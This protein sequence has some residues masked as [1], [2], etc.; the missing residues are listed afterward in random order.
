MGR[1]IGLLSRK[2]V[3]LVG[4]GAQLSR[5]CRSGVRLGLMRLRLRL[6]MRLPCARV[7]RGEGD[8][9]LVKGPRCGRRDGT[10]RIA[11]GRRIRIGLP[12]PLLL[13][14]P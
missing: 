9:V 13:K 14:K 2:R 5:S 6:R 11:R 8:G 7:G 10:R 1:R 4:L 12:R 3:H